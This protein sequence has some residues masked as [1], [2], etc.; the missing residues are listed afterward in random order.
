VDIPRTIVSITP[1]WLTAALKSGGSL[2]SGGVISVQF[3]P[4]GDRK[5][6][7]AEVATGVIKY[8]GDPG[9]AHGTIVAKVT[10]RKD[11]LAKR[12]AREGVYENEARIYADIGDDIGVPIPRLYYAD[13]DIETGLFVLLLEDLSGLR[14]VDETTGCSLKD[15]LVVVR[16]AAR[17]HARWWNSDRLNQLPWLLRPLEARW[18]GLRKAEYI[19]NWNAGSRILKVHLSPEVYE[20]AERLGP[21]Y[22]EVMSG[23]PPFALTLNHDDYHLGNMFF[24]GGEVTTIDWQ[25]AN[26]GP[27]TLHGES[28][29]QHEKYVRNQD[30]PIAV[31]YLHA[32][33]ELM[34]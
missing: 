9:S 28:R 21:K 1:E 2:A 26:H 3:D 22:A 25:F 7:F 10:I 20:I 12:F 17:L 32:P 8:S 11:E 27:P 23:T 31:L 15:A 34:G 29:P 5:G 33:P 16:N 13:S 30:I 19:A 24:G 4:P 6:F 14:V 18:T